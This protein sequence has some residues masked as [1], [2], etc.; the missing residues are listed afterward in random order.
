MAIMAMA[1]AFANFNQVVLSPKT[2][3]FI[4]YYRF[5]KQL[6]RRVPPPSL[7]QHQPPNR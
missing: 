6:Q 4:H 7:T 3:P 5:I 1:I 2:R